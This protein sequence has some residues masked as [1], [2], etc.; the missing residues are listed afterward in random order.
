MPPQ[1][2]PGGTSAE[3]MVFKNFLIQPSSLF[4]QDRHAT[5]SPERRP[6]SKQLPA[7]DFL[8]TK[9]TY[10]DP[11][12]EARLREQRQGALQHSRLWINGW[13]D[14]KQSWQF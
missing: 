2:L 14:P 13:L 7:Q 5:A 12:A 11:H 10:T 3:I 4:Q 9:E 1:A 6:L 8:M